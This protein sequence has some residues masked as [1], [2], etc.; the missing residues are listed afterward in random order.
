MD[1]RIAIHRIFAGVARSGRA[2]PLSVAA[3]NFALSD[4]L[5]RLRIA[6]TG[7]TYGW[8]WSGSQGALAR[9]LWPIIRAAG[10]LLTGPDLHRV[11]ICGGDPC[12]FMFVDTSRRGRRWCDMNLCGKRAK[13]RRYYERTHADHP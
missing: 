6:E 2:D 9:P 4:A 5:S 13:N 10:E 7:D 8:D 12:G 3:L 11:R 1:A